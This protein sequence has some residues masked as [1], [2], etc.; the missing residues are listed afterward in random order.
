MPILARDRPRRTGNRWN[1]I[2]KRCP[3]WLLD[4][5]K[6]SVAPNGGELWECGTT[7]GSTRSIFRII[8]LP[9]RP[10]IRTTWRFEAKWIT[11]RLGRSTRFN[12]AD[13]SVD[14]WHTALQDTMLGCL[15]RLTR[16]V[17]PPASAIGLRRRWPPSNKRLPLCLNGRVLRLLRSPLT[18]GATG[19]R[20]FRSAYLSDCCFPV[21]S[22]RTFWPPSSSWRPIVPAAG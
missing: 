15:I 11:R 18:T 1:T 21:W 12:A 14:Y 17:G 20:L 7:W 8:S 22:M 10:T 4:L 6:S 13:S 3:A 19:Q 16:L 5:P 2:S 9:P